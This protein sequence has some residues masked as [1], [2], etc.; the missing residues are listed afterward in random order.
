MDEKGF[1]TSTIDRS[2]LRLVQTP[3]TFNLK[4]YRILL[5]KALAFKKDYT[6]DCQLFEAEGGKIKLIDGEM[7]NIKITYKEDIVHANAIAKFY[8]EEQK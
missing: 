2:N 4:K 6:D 5:Y 1:I 3:Q 7:N 8:S